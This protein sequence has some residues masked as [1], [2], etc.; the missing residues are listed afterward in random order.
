MAKATKCRSC[1]YGNFCGT[2]Q[3][4]M[5]NYILITGNARGC[6]PT[7]CDKHIPKSRKRSKMGR[8]KGNAKE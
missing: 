5:C 4:Y 1:V 8:R 2:S 7:K 6:P 3:T